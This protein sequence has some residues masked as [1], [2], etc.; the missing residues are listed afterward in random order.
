[1]ATAASSSSLSLYRF[2]VISRP[3]PL[4]FVL[5]NFPRAGTASA[6]SDAVRFRCMAGQ[7]GFFTRLG[8]LL[9]EKAKSDVDK[10]F[11]GFSKTRNNLAVI[12]ELLLY[13]NLADTDRVLDEL[14]E[15]FAYLV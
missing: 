4:Q 1:M 2:S 8:R 15:V 7:T 3:S 5:F 11:S 14:E 12:D 13:W 6:R 10:I 9:Q